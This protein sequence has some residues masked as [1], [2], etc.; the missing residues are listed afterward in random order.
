MNLTQSHPLTDRSHF[1]GVVAVPVY[2]SQAAL[3]PVA[4]ALDTRQKLAWTLQKTPQT[5]QFLWRHWSPAPQME[6]SPNCLNKWKS[7]KAR[8][9]VA[10]FVVKIT[11]HPTLSLIATRFKSCKVLKEFLLLYCFY[12]QLSPEHVDMLIFKKK[13]KLKKKIHFLSAKKARGRDGSSM[14]LFVP[15]KAKCLFKG[16]LL[17]YMPLI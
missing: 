2:F 6:T 15:L 8:S 13:K 5:S 10:H 3:A 16:S 7:A 11:S 14:L 12:S 1:I 17:A 9:V 4:S